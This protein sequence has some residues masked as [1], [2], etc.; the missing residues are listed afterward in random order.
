MGPDLYRGPDYNYYNGVLMA[1][2]KHEFTDKDME[3]MDDLA[4]LY[5]KDYT[6]A[7]VLGVSVKT[8]T[9]RFS[10][11]LIKKRAEGKAK[12]RRNQANIA[13]NNSQMAIFLGKNVLH[14]ADKQEMVHSFDWRG[15]AKDGSEA[16]KP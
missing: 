8:L 11:R 16:T 7:Q 9:S 2:P 3:I 13:E 10:K 4:A 14:Q 5:C 12:L 15:L 6:I 1:R